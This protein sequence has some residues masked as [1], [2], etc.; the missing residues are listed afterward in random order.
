VLYISSEGVVLAEH[1]LEAPANTALAAKSLAWDPVRD[2]IWVTTDRLP[3]PPIDDEQSPFAHPAIVLDREGR[4]V[5]RF[6]SPDE[7]VEIQFVRFD[8]RGRGYLAVAEDG[9]LDLV[10]FSPEAD[11]REWS[12]ARRV[13]L[14]AR[15]PAQLDFAQ[16]I[17]V[18]E[19][20]SA[21]VARWSGAVHRVS[22]EGQ[23]LTWRLPLPKDSLY[24]TAVPTE[25]GICATRCRDVE[26]VC[27]SDAEARPE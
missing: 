6:G 5:A 7:P 9:A 13:R 15:F 14:D 20:G 12:A 3:L 21:Y 8:A 16:D 19:D 18:T 2:E 23:V 22:P 27:A 4:E 11:R 25:N 17:Q 10:V 24:Y 26:V 1:R